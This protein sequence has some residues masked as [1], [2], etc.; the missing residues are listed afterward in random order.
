M[1]RRVFIPCFVVIAIGCSS[2]A[3]QAQ[4]VVHAL[5]GTVQSVR[6]AK[7][8]MNLNTD[9]GSSG[10]FQFPETAN[11]NVSFDKDVRAE[12]EPADKL[13]GDAHQVILF[14]FGVDLVRTAFAVE[15]LGTGPFVKVTGTVVSFNKHDHTLT[16]QTNA[17]PPQTFVVGDKT[18]VDT[19][20]GVA[21]GHGFKAEKGDHLRLLAESK[22]GKQQAMLIRTSGIDAAI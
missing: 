11:I 3:V 5:G 20:G 17:G 6:A 8:T 12:T 4:W 9:D 14:F 21:S 2:A 22:D 10:E 16:L 15:D 13:S 7:K 19:A 1:L 18:V